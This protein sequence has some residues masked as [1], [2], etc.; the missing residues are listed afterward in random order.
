M[1]A[2]HIDAEKRYDIIRKTALRVTENQL[3]AN[4]GLN[5]KLID[6][7]ALQASQKWALS[8]KR[9]VNW[10]WLNGYGDFKYRYP[11]RFELALWLKN[12]LAS[13][14]LGRPTYQGTGLRLD[15]IEGNPDNREVKVFPITMAAMAT[16]AEALGAT[17]LRVMN[18]INDDVKHYYEKFGLT[19][20]AKGDYLYTRL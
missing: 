8:Q 16:Y 2:T 9:L 13:L 19:Y 20:V 4:T 5:F 1:L 7:E 15:F 6:Q 14:T 12:S 18:P 3:T 10:D 17:Q 11:K